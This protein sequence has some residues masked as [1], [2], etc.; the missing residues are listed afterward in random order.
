[1]KKL[2]LSLDELHVESFDTRTGADARRGTVPAHMATTPDVCVTD[3]NYC[4]S[5]NYSE[6]RSCIQGTC[7]NSCGGT[8]GA[9]SCAASCAGYTCPPQCW[10]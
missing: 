1:M 2:R 9:L 6:C 10:D 5:D 3:P 7:Y 4:L 8:C